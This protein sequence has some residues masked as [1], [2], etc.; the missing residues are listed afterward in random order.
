MEEK[1]IEEKVLREL[2]RFVATLEAKPDTSSTAF[3]KNKKT[4]KKFFTKVSLFL[5]SPRRCCL[6]TR[7]DCL[8]EISDIDPLLFFRLSSP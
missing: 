2:D 1:S 5:F 8:D 4:T 7:C 6:S 3:L